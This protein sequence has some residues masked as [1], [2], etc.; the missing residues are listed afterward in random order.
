MSRRVFDCF[1]FNAELDLLEFR[2]DLLADLVDHHVVVEAPRTYSGESKPLHFA[3]NQARFARHADRI[4]HVMVDDLP[5]PDP[6]QNGRWLPENFQRRA[7]AR[8]LTEAEP[9]DIVLLCDVDEIPDPAVLST[10]IGGLT[11]PV[12]LDMRLSYLRANW[13]S[14]QRWTLAKAAPFGSFDDLQQLR[15]M[16]SSLLVPSAGCH[17]SYLMGDDQISVKLRTYAHDE[18]DTPLFTDPHFLRTCI[19]GG[20]FPLTNEP[21]RM[22]PLTDLDAVQRK[23]LAVRPDLFDFDGLPSPWLRHLMHGYLKRRQSRHV[24]ASARRGADAVLSR[25]VGAQRSG[26]AGDRRHG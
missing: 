2:L 3:E 20:F 21:L 4:T 15:I 10:V 19:A 16:P 14:S 9:D 25:V 18:F 17:F 8:G 7:I 26:P 23:L 11:Q 22:V 5:L 24:P 6:A 12:A 13:T 1:L